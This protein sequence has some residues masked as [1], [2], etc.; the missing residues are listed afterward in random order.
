MEQWHAPRK[1]SS[2]FKVLCIGASMLRTIE[3]GW[4]IHLLLN[5]HLWHEHFTWR[6]GRSRT[7]HRLAET[8]RIRAIRGYSTLGNLGGFL[9]NDGDNSAEF[10]TVIRAKCLFT[11]FFVK[12]NIPLS[13][14]DHTALLF[15]KMFPKCNEVKHSEYGQRQRQLL[16]VHKNV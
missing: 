9:Q 15:Q 4:D 16:N 6:Q 11:A 1:F 2:L 7:A 10:C 8:L 3:K 13:M 14:S 5:V 12:H